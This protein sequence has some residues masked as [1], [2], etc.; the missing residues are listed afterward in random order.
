MRFFQD[1]ISF[2]PSLLNGSLPFCSIESILFHTQGQTIV[3]FFHYEP[4]NFAWN[5][6]LNAPHP[7]TPEQ[8]PPLHSLVRIIGPIRFYPSDGTYIFCFHTSSQ[9]QNQGQKKE[10]N[11]R[12]LQFLWNLM[13]F[14]PPLP[15]KQ[16]PFA[17]VHGTRYFSVP[18]S[19]SY[20]I[21]FLG[22]KQMFM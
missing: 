12:F 6:W 8:Q 3:L 2:F 15:L 20:D 7:P 14:I 4:Y 19:S 5:H 9:K 22:E 17:E 1:I 18:P 21:R 13:C 10:D 11:L 16:W